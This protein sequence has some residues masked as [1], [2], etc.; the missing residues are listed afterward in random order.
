[1]DNSFDV[2][3]VEGISQQTIGSLNGGVFVITYAEYLSN[4]LQV[5]N[6]GLD[7]RLIH[8]R[9]AAHLWKYG[10]AKAQKSYARNIKDPRRSK[11]NSIA[12]NKEQLVHIE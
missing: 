5:P 12:P 1:M 6:D 4:G 9:Y 7:I 8:K 10:E 3:C 11:P 2:Q